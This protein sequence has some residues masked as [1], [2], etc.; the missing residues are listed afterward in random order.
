VIDSY[1]SRT[2][3]GPTLLIGAALSIPILAVA[4]DLLG[5]VELVEGGFPVEISTFADIAGV[6]GSILLTLALVL[7]YREQTK[8]QGR[9]EKWMEAEHVP[10]VFVEEWEVTR[11]R[12]DFE[13]SNLGTGVARNLRVT[14]E[15]ETE[16]K[17]GV[18]NVTFA[19]PLSRQLSSARV[20]RPDEND[21]V[22]VDGF[23]EVSGAQG[24]IEI[25]DT[26]IESVSRWLNG[27]QPPS[28]I[29]VTI[30]YDY[31]RRRSGS[32]QVFSCEVDP[33]DAETVEDI[34]LSVIRRNENEV[35]IEPENL[36]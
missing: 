34:L 33:T 20:L 3:S 6:F 1:R 28:N 5:V 26:T 25:S 12:A 23:F 30:E 14:I 10:D 15:V 31:I 13:L 21:V 29:V 36:G 19:A 18:S 35:D 9:Q 24:T 32:Q 7:L 4:L 11:N 17:F 8:I 16:D 27:D 2:P 22:V